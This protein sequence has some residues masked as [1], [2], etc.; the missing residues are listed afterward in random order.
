MNSKRDHALDFLKIFATL[1]I[2]LHHYERAFG[3]QFAG[4]NFG[5]GKFYFGYAVE[6]FFMISGFVAFFSVRKIQDG[7]HFDRYF[8]GKVLRLLPL[9]ALSTAVF[10]AMFV[11]VWGTKDFSLFKV[12]VTAFCVQQ[13]GPFSEFLVNS[14]LWYLSVL[15]ICYAFFFLIVRTGQRLQIDWRYGAFFMILLGASITSASWDLPYLNEFAARGYMAFFT[16]LLLSSV[17]QGRRPGWKAFAA[18]L[19]VVTATVLLIIFR[20][21]IMEYGLRYI[22]IF[23][24]YP[25]LIVL[26]ETAPLQKILS[27]RLLGTMAQIAFNVYIWHFDFNTF[28]AVA[29]D[30]LGLGIDFRTRKAELAVLLLITAA[31]TFSFYLI[32]RPIAERIRRIRSLS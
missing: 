24:F 26:F 11:V 3:T 32:E 12:L 5:N 19:T 29:N 25:A 6:L 1:V 28:C 14:H 21:E 16:G 17:L 20:F 9:A 7:L 23:V 22:L 4:L 31:G 2:V 10:A 8:S 27:H 13:G 18:G 15:L 30:I